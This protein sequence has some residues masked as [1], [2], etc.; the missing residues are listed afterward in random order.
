VVA[1]GFLLLLLCSFLPWSGGDIS[2]AGGSEELSANAWSG[3]SPWLMR[4]FD[5]T[6]D[7][8][9]TSAQGGTVESGTDMLILFPLAL[10]AVGV[11]LAVRLGKRFERSAEIGLA[12][13]VLLAILLI[14]EAIHVSGALDDFNGIL[15]TYGA[16][17]DFGL[18]V[19]FFGGVVAAI[20]MAVGA[21]R[22]YLA[23]KQPAR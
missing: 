1:V 14:V 22:T 3:D 16:R 19:G 2:G 10:G 21:G 15:A 18:Q 17:A 9:L 5:V 23:S 6:E 7:N 20:L 13:A 8:V 11:A 4:G 12:L